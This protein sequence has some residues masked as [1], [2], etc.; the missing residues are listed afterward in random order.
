MWV[1]SRQLGEYKRARRTASITNVDFALPPPPPRDVKFKE[2]TGND[3]DWED[4]DDS[5][6]ATEPEVEREDLL[7]MD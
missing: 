6:E 4:E 1:Y 3:D 2:P 5:L 7:V